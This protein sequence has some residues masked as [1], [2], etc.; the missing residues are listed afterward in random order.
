MKIYNSRTSSLSK[1]TGY[2]PQSQ[3]FFYKLLFYKMSVFIGAE[4]HCHVPSTVQ[5]HPKPHA[6]RTAG[7]N[8]GG[9]RGAGGRG[10][11]DA[12]DE[13]E[14]APRPD[15]APRPA[16]APRPDAAPRAA[17]AAAA[18]AA[19]RAAPDTAA[20]SAPIGEDEEDGG[21]ADAAV[22]AA[23]NAATAEE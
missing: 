4:G 20:A 10:G 9:G 14:A 15:A 5:G 17:A 2:I 21:A 16:A 3:Y 7:L 11:G 6:R 22:N 1:R 18:R 23:V 19:P 12:E 13:A 8:S